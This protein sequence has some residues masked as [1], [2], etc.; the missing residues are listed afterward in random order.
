[1]KKEGNVCMHANAPLFSTF[2]L[3]ATPTPSPFLKSDMPLPYHLHD[4]ALF[5]YCC[6]IKYIIIVCIFAGKD[7]AGRTLLHN[8]V[9]YEHS[10]IVEYLIEQHSNLINSVDNVSLVFNIY[11]L[12][13]EIFFFF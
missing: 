9:L 10:D 6:N 12:A 1:M 13:A 4:Q 7:K 2:R 5:E 11:K 3:P 8:A